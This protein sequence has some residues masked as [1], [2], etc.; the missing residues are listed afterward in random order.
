LSLGNAALGSDSLEASLPEASSRADAPF[1]PVRQLGQRLAAERLRLQLREVEDAH[2]ELDRR[3]ETKKQ[4]R[5]RLA[6]EQSE[7]ARGA[8]RERIAEQRRAE[9]AGR[10]RAE[11]EAQEQAARQRRREAI[12]NVKRQVVEFWWPDVTARS[13]LKSRVVKEIE[14]GLEPLPVEDIPR[15]ELVLIAEGIRD[16]LYVAQKASEQHAQSS[17]T[18]RNGLITYGTEYAAHELRSVDGLPISDIWRIERQIRSDLESIDGSETRDDIE[19]R[20]E[21]IF[22]EEGIG[23]DE[24]DEE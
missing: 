2:S 1:D 14:I 17:T 12:Q 20:V 23:W 4:E 6:R 5:D 21:A 22:E 11:R 3:T 24:D 15:G 16:R 18:R 13:D 7:A 19:D 9:S 10:E 8:E